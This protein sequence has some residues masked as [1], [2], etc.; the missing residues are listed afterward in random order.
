M[1][2]ILPI[3]INISNIPWNQR[4]YSEL[5]RAKSRCAELYSDAPCLKKFIKVRELTYRVICGV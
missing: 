5:D 2:C 1:T 4:D 3:L